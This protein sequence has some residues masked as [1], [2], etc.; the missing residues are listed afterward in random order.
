MNNKISRL[1]IFP[2]LMSPVHLESVRNS[3]RT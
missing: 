2:S 1:E 3:S